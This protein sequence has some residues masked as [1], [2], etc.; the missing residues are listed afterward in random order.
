MAE[1]KALK[2]KP[3]VKS[4]VKKIAAAKAAATTNYRGG[5]KSL[6]NVGLTKAARA[7][8]ERQV[9]DADKTAMRARMIQSK[10]KKAK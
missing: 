8:L 3:I 6:I 9:I 5:N 4:T 1:K 2:A 7:K 10:A